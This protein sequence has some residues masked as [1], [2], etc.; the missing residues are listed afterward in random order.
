MVSIKL[1]DGAVRQFDKPVSV[2]DVAAAI[3]PGLAKAALA[4]KVNGK[5]VDTSTLIEADADREVA[6]VHGLQQ[7]RRPG[8]LGQPAYE[9][10]GEKGDAGR[11]NRGASRQDHYHEPHSRERQAVEKTHEGRAQRPQ[12]ADE[13]PLRGVA[14]RLRERG[15][16]GYWYPEHGTSVDKPTPGCYDKNSSNGVRTTMVMTPLTCTETF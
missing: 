12:L 10:P 3:G 14:H 13:M 8:D 11:G 4:G 2:K 9:A 15:G 7:Q 16:D 5:L 6:L 1:P